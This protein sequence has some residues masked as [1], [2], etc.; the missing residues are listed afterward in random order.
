MPTFPDIRPGAWRDGDQWS[1]RVWA[2]QAKTLQLV[3]LGPVEQI[4]DMERDEW[5]Y[6]STTVDNLEDGRRYAYLIDGDTK[7]YPDP[8]SRHQPDGVHGPSALVDLPTLEPSPWRGLPLSQL[9]IYEL[10][11]GTFTPE[12]TFDA[13]IGKLDYLA[14]LGVNA[15]EVMPLSQFPGDRNWGY[16]GVAPYA[17]VDSYGGPAGLQRFIAACHER[18]IAVL[19]DVVYNHLGPEGNYLPL[20]GPYFTEAHRTP[21]G[22]AI[23][24]DDKG[25]DG[26]RNYFVQN[27]L[28]WLREY[29]ADGLRLDAVHAI[30]DYSAQ[31]F[32]AQL[33]EAVQEL[34]RETEREYVLL[35]ECDLNAPH[36]LLPVSGGGYG[37]SGQWVDEFHHALHAYLT[38][39]RNGY[40]ADFGELEHIER[41][42]RNGYVYTGQYS[43]HRERN[44]GRPTDNLDPGRLVVFLQNHDQVGNRATGD[45]LIHTLSKKQY[46]LAAGTYLLSPYVPLIFMG[47]EYGETAP[48]QYFVSHG[49]PDLIEAVRK[50]RASEFAYFQREGVEVP[51][52]QSEKTFQRSKLSWQ[53]D[54]RILAFYKS[55]IQLRR[56]LNERAIYDFDYVKVEQPV[57]GLLYWTLPLPA[58]EPGVHIYANFTD[59]EQSL[60]DVDL[61]A[62]AV[63]LESQPLTVHK[64]GAALPPWGLVVLQ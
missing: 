9:I 60:P 52:P 55:C 22:S 62:M 14:D 50:G 10:H 37:L 57:P 56:E 13:A 53:P 15:L 36:F 23:N 18:G 61:A 2:P 6:W 19:I 25:A 12:G 47:E 1:F 30:K 3:I 27:A 7:R 43:P 51:D 21:W 64:T 45:R 5:G 32:L 39:E 28:M 4:R 41:A 29:G 42:L 59:R 63:R 34:H 20:F 17:V 48:F 44:F 46:L 49:D 16:D 38:G 35:A 54:E 58:D 26:V 31:H 24:M 33:S 11:I 8:A 40:Y